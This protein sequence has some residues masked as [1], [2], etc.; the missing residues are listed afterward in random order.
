[1]RAQL[2]GESSRYTLSFTEPWLFDIPLSGGIDIYNAIRDYDTYDKDSVGGTIRLSYPVFDYTRAYL[3]YNYDRSKI[4][5]ITQDASFEI[6]EWEGTNTG[7]TVTGVLRRDSRDRIFNPSEG[8]DN[9]IKVEHAGTPF[10]GDVGY[11][12]YVADSGWYF[13]LFWDTVGLLHGRI[14][15]IHNDPVGDTPTWERFYLGGMQSVR[16]YDWREISPRDPVTGDEVG[17]N[18]MLQFNVEFI[19]PIAKQAGLMGVLFYD[20]GN[21]YDNG[22]DIDLADLRDSVGFG[23]RWYSPMGPLRLE[24][25]YILDTDDRGDGEQGDSRWEFSMGMAF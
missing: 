9:S 12:K 11:T 2:G 25:G 10:G 14:G 21:A 3:S 16:G 13:P 1:V 17:G 15:F 8:S 4:E 6:R 19:L 23:V 18:K 22:E 20:T 5:D 24:Y 7:H